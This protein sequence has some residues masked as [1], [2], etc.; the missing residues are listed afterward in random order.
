MAVGCHGRRFQRRFFAWEA[1]AHS[2]HVFRAAQTGVMTRVGFSDGTCRIPD[3]AYACQGE[4]CLIYALNSVF[5]RIHL[6]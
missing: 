1:F 2:G 4:R 6:R 3:A 5:I